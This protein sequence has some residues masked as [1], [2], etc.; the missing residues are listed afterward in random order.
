MKELE[1]QQ[2]LTTA[3]RCAKICL[4]ASLLAQEQMEQK[5]QVLQHGTDSYIMQT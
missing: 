4:E 3:I 1:V 5:L 2:R